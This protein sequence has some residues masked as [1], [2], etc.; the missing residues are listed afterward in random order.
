MLAANIL[1]AI[2]A[3][4]WKLLL[5]QTQELLIEEPVDDNMFE[6]F[7]GTEGRSL[8]CDQIGQGDVDCKKFVNGKDRPRIVALFPAGSPA[9]TDS[10]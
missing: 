8:L 3:V 9:P 6:R 4:A 2:C 5:D 1:Q 7:V 10:W